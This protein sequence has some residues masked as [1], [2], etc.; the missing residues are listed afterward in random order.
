VPIQ[1][2]VQAPME[3]QTLGALR[4]LCEEELAVLIMRCCGDDVLPGTVKMSRLR[5]RD[6][7]L[8]V[9]KTEG[10]D[11][12]FMPKVWNCVDFA[13]CGGQGGGH[14]RGH[15][16]GSGR[17]RGR[18]GGR[19]APATGPVDFM[20][21]FDEPRQ[22][23]WRDDAGTG[24]PGAA[25]A[26]E[27]DGDGDPADAQPIQE[28]L[29]AA[30]GLPPEVFDLSEVAELAD[31]LQAE[32]LVPEDF[33]QELQVVLGELPLEEDPV[34]E[35]GEPPAD[36]EHEPPVDAEHEPPADAEHEPPADA[37][38][39]PPVD[40]EHEPPADAEHEPPADEVHELPLR[41]IRGKLSTGSG[42]LVGQLHTVGKGPKATCKVHAS[43]VCWVSLHSAGDADALRQDLTAW[44][45]EAA[46]D[47]PASAEQHQISAYHLKV[48]WGMKPR[49]PPGL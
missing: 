18:G 17:G 25:A 45:S 20:D 38:H 15:A 33:W 10:I 43:C 32:L 39:E 12:S 44:V 9:I 16:H 21:I 2:Q 40:A 47:P 36:A 11:G 49:K 30:L 24:A 28:E 6:E 14:G 4:H 42:R 41:E 5:Y 27:L 19:Q 31:H 29:A 22:S 3:R 8:D 23:F 48:K 26:E 13:A 1:I 35:I 46:G 7:A 34:E 37:E